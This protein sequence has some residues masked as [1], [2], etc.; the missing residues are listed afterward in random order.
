MMVN[1]VASRTYR[2]TAPSVIDAPPSIQPPCIIEGN[3]LHSSEPPMRS[4]L[5]IVF[6]IATTQLCSANEP[7]PLP[8]AHQ[9]KALHGWT[10]KVDERLLS[11]EHEMQGQET[12]SLIDRRLADIVLMLPKDKVDR[13]R[14]VPIQLD[15]THGKL[16]SAQY[17]PSA[18]W[19]KNNGYSE[20]L[21]KVVH[22][23]F[24]RDYASKDHQRIQPWSLLHELAHAYHDQ[25]LD[26]ENEEIKAAY[27]RFKE[28]G[29]YESILHINGHKTWHYG[30]TNQKEF[31]AELTE[32][33]FGVNDFYPFNRAE[34]MQAEPEIHALLKKIWEESR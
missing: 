20:A 28:R 5:L 7:P 1:V 9:S 32:S 26:F 2:N 14:K 8:S 16:T 15:L 11:G 13:L 4:I 27:I 6:L 3:L 22:I 31:F 25:V 10:I 23:P 18:G 24:A 29:V 21:A 12:L 30:L 17:H 19:L 33:Y 34:L